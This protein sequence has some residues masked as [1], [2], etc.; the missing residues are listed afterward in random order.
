MQAKSWTFVKKEKWGEGPWQHEP[1]K[2]QFADPE[3]GLPCLIHRGPAGQLCGYVGITEGHKFFGIKYSDCSLPEAKPRGPRPGDGEPTQI[4]DR[5]L[6]P[7]P[8]RI[9]KMMQE[10]KQC[11][12]DGHCSHCPEAML[13]VHGGITFSEFCLEMRADGHGI[14]HVA[15]PGEPEK[16]WWFGFDCAHLG[17]LCPA[18][19]DLLGGRKSVMREGDYR[20]VAYVQQ[21]IAQL[22]KQLKA[23]A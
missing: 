17:D 19:G 14:C 18:Y 20:D 23:L 5:T 4:G 7:M 21:E 13:D 9:V 2:M 12:E 22:A 1:D 10:R 8:E 6:P 11:N 3:T 15:D 16:V